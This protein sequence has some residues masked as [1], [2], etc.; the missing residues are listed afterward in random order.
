MPKTVTTIGMRVIE[1][2]TVE[3]AV[4]DDANVLGGVRAPR[5]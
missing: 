5:P 2:R 4:T 3:A 1:P